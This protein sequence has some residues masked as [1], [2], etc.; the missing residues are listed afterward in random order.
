MRIHGGDNP[1]DATGIHPESYTVANDILKKVNAEVEEIFPRWL[2]QP[3]SAEIAAQKRAEAAA[4]EA[5]KPKQPAPEFGAIATGEPAVAAA[6]DAPA[7]PASEAEVQPPAT[8]PAEVVVEAVTDSTAE[9]VPGVAVE[10][11][12]TAEPA[13][14]TAP[15]ETAPVAEGTPAPKAEPAAAPEASANAETADGPKSERH[16]FDQRRKL[17]VKSMSELDLSEIAT[18]HGT[19]SL[20]VKDIVM[21]LK[22]P[23][24]DPR[25]KVRKPI[26]RRGIVKVDDLKPEMQLE[27]QVVNVVDFGVF[28][29]I[30]LGESSLVHVSQLSNHYIADPHKV[31]AV[32]DAMKVWVTEV[33]APQRRVRL[34]AIRPGSKKAGSRGRSNRS[35]GK[36]GPHSRSTGS[37]EKSAQ[38]SPAQ[39]GSG[40][41][42]GKYEG[43]RGGR[44]SGPSRKDNPK[45]KRDTRRAKP[46][47]VKPIT[48]KMLKGDEPMRSFSDLAQFV[49]RKPDDPKDD[50]NKS[51]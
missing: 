6:T 27:G 40:R 12:V 24:W 46:K 36:S 3:A 25:D 41:R 11:T 37:G 20:A 22:R 1:L 44:S 49:K 10:S 17:I 30:G 16:H 28:V 35:A 7:V 26:F 50:K 43:S 9:A 34:T 14:P 2:M 47:P 39:S 21:T 29:D 48:D 19:G 13:A 33:S 51:K 38:G 42:P 4:S 23:A 15:V 32:G 5:A 45:F 31:F 8:A 18:Q